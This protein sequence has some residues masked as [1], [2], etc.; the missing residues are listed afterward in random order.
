[1]SPQSI[2]WCFWSNDEGWLTEKISYASFMLIFCLLLL[3]IEVV[4]VNLV[5]DGPVTMQLDSS[6]LR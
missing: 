3:I 5:N 4:Q 2:R 1:M 6:V